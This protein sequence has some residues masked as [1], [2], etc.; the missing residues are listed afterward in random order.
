[1][2]Y[3]G[4]LDN[5]KYHFCCVSCAPDNICNIHNVRIHRDVNSAYSIFENALRKSD[6][7][8]CPMGC[9]LSSVC[10]RNIHIETCDKVIKRRKLLHDNK[11]NY[12]SELILYKKGTVRVI[13]PNNDI[14]I[15]AL[16]VDGTLQSVFVEEWFAPDWVIECKLCVAMK[17]NVFTIAH[18]KKDGTFTSFSMGDT[19]RVNPVV[20]VT[21]TYERM[22]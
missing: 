11:H 6:E 10:N 21:C 1:M 3:G 20:H 8:I 16:F 19:Y 15:R 12:N 13:T 5:G 18:I 22:V 9:L 2:A 4:C 14:Q 7:L 17:D